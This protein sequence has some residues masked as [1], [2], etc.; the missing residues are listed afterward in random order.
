MANITHGKDAGNVAFEQVRVAIER[1]TFESLT[2]E[3][4][5]GS[6]Q[7]KATLVSLHDVCEPVRSRQSPDEDKHRARRHALNLASIRTQN[8]DL[9]QMGFTMCLRHAS[10]SPDSD[11]R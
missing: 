8:G 3:H 11:I 6:G 10:V 9:L 5:I 7:N 1:P 4:E 2:F